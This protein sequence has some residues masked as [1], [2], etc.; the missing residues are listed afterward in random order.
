M[1]FSSLMSSISGGEVKHGADEYTRKN[2]EFPPLKP[3]FRQILV[4]S[5]DNILVWTYRKNRDEESRFFDSFDPEGSFIG[6]VQVVGE[7]L[8]PIMAEINNGTF[9]IRKAD[10]DG[11]IKLVKYRISE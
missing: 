8:F 11:F 4:D 6:C 10:E 2:T 9:W 7:A 5:D 3:A 1:F